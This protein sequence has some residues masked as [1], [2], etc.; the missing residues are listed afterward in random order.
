MT[1]NPQLLY[2]LLAM[3]VYHRGE[4][5]GLAGLVP[6]TEIEDTER[7]RSSVLGSAIGFFAQSYTFNGQTIIAYRGTDD[8]AKLGA[9]LDLTYGVK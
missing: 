8:G 2:A 1:T 6:D 9:S 4:A 5:G 7:G 3:D